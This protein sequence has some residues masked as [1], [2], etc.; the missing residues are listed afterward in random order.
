MYSEIQMNKDLLIKAIC[1]FGQ[2]AQKIRAAQAAAGLSE[3]LLKDVSGDPHNIEEG[4]AELEIRIAQL[5]LIYSQA[6]IDGF[7]EA[8]IER[9]KRQ[10]D[11]DG[12]RY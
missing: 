6:T 1:R 11:K 4:I 8:K 3:A 12:F 2:A 9:L 7:I 5:R 10:I